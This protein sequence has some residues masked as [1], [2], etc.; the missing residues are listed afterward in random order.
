ML[1]EHCA[2]GPDAIAY[3][4]FAR[5]HALQRRQAGL[6]RVAAAHAGAD[7]GWARRHADAPAC[8]SLDGAVAFERRRVEAAL[9]AAHGAETPLALVSTLDATR[10]RRRE[11]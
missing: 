9:A 1:C 3:D 4:H 2:A 5:V 7:A 10:K 6:A 11:S 8:A